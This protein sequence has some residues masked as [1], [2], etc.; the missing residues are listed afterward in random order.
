MRGRTP[1]PACCGCRGRPT[2]ART[3]EFQQSMAGRRIVMPAGAPLKAL[4]DLTECQGP[5][6]A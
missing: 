6:V 5:T 3:Y 4:L 2:T 1:L